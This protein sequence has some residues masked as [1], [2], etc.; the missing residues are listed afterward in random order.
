VAP[1]H[2]PLIALS[3]Q[4]EVFVRCAEEVCPLIN[5]GNDLHVVMQFS[6]HKTDSMLKRYHVINV[7][8]LRQAALRGAAYS[9]Q[10]ASIV[11]MHAAGENPDRTR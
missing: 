8:D 10:S 7:D 11:P 2:E 5:A 1:R 6:G 4:A 9:G 3:E